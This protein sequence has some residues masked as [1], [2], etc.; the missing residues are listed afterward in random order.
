MSRELIDV[1]NNFGTPRVLVMGDI[2]LDRYVWGDAERISQ[3]APVILLREDRRECRLGGAANVANMLSCLETDVTLAGLIGKDEDGSDTIEELKR[4]GVSPD[5]ITIDPT[6]PTT[7]KQR[8]LGT[9]QQKHPHQILRVDRESRADVAGEPADR[10]LMAVLEAMENTDVVLISDYGKGV[11]TPRIIRSVIQRARK[12]DIPVI[13]D[14]S[15]SGKCDEFRG[16]TALTPNRTETA[17]AVGTKIQ[18]AED[19][20]AA[21]RTLVAGL[22][23]DH[24]FITLDSDGMAVIREDGTANLIPTRKRHVYDITGAGDMVLATIGLGTAV[25]M[26]PED[27]ARLANVAGGLEVEQVGC[28]PITRRE[29]IED[30]AKHDAVRPAGRVVSTLNEL[31]VQI[32]GHRQAGERIVFTNG[33]FDILHAGHVTYL[34]QAAAQG[35]RL[36]VAVNSDASVRSL[37]KGDDRPIIAEQERAQLLAALKAVDYVIIFDEPTPHHLLQTLRPDVLVKGGTYTREQIVGHEIVDAYGG[38]VRPLTLVPGRSTTSLVERIRA[39]ASESNK[40]VLKTVE[41][42][43]KAA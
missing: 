41:P 34:E 10:L 26:S 36:I 33:C 37:G 30:L 24:I 27:L 42:E 17:R 5:A 7:V 18:S 29:I 25:G 40:P 38:E 28:V 4:A 13:V 8:F 9:A 32:E 14:P 35:D 39:T 3:E 19:A 22:D 23:L 43:S 6:R 1:V 20:F 21:G 15:S 2:I 31:A 12:M 11:C 16:A